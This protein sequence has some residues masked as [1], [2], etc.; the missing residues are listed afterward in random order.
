MKVRTTAALTLS[1]LCS[2]LCFAS[3]S[4]PAGSAARGPGEQTNKV[5]EAEA[6]LTEERTGLGRAEGAA[7]QARNEAD[8]AKEAS[9]A[10]QDKAREA[11]DYA[12]SVGKNPDDPNDAKKSYKVIQA[13]RE[14]EDEA[15]RAVAKAREADTEVENARKRVQD[16][17][18]KLKAAQGGTDE[19]LSL[20]PQWLQYALVALAGVMVLVAAGYFINQGLKGVRARTDA[21]FASIADLQGKLAGRLEKS[22]AEL[23]QKVDALSTQ[24]QGDI[25]TINDKLNAL[26]A[27]IEALRKA[28]AQNPPGGGGN[29]H[30]QAAPPKEE[31][32][33]PVSA[34]EYLFKARRGA[35][36]VKSDM[37]KGILVND[38][39]GTGELVLVEDPNVP[40]G[41]LYVIPRTGSFKTRQEF[42]Y[43]EKYYDC[44]RLTAGTVWIVEPA[45]V[46]RVN[47]GWELKDKGLL[48]IRS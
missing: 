13:G 36:V 40:G 6:K 31:Q 47:G 7:R 24:Q 15:N 34:E 48:E 14:A 42:S 35:Q 17:E 28:M 43:Y 38:P 41:L 26:W 5:R 27:N 45:V 25:K 29:Y 33:F 11:R 37:F 44:H 21:R 39:E 19:D 22:V 16:A 4:L 30:E 32:P 8:K 1:A 18:I 9:A 12:V 2:L 10:A 3:C 20:F 23:G 46:N